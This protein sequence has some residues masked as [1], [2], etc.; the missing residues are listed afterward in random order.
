MVDKMNYCSN[1]I[2]ENCKHCVIIEDRSEDMRT[3]SAYCSK[4]YDIIEVG[5]MKWR[6]LKLC[7]EWSE[8]D[9]EFI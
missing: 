1:N 3:P 8:G 6:P 9:P 7:G 4:E 5:I 2:C